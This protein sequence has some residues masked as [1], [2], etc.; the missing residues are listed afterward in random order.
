MEWKPDRG[1]YQ[2]VENNPRVGEYEIIWCF[3]CHDEA[4]VISNDGKRGLCWDHY[5]AWC[6]AMAPD[7]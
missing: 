6:E 7:D 1:E 4:V 2:N 3:V 5:S